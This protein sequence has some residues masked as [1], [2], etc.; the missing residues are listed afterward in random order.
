MHSHTRL[1][2]SCRR[3]TLMDHQ[4]HHSSSHHHDNRNLSD[5]PSLYTQ[6]RAQQ[7]EMTPVH[8]L[9]ADS[10]VAVSTNRDVT[11]PPDEDVRLRSSFRQHRTVDSVFLKISSSCYF[12]EGQETLARFSS[13]LAA[14]LI[15]CI[16]SSFCFLLSSITDGLHSGR[17]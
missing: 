10:L 17:F 8:W 2:S 12:R 1:H 3:N 7:G 5:S 4:H 15:I 16:T 9:S 13:V 6:L 14:S 11:G